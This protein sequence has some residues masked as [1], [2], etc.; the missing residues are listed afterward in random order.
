[1]TATTDYDT[2]ERRNPWPGGS[3][4]RVTGEDDLRL[5]V[6]NGLAG[7]TVVV[8]G[9]VLNCDGELIPFEQKL[10]PTTDRLASTV[11]VRLSEG[12]LVQAHAFVSAGSPLVGQTFALLSV[13]R[14]DAAAAIDLFTLAAGYVTAT[15]RASFPS[16][17][18]GSSLRFDGAIRSITGT[19]PGAGA[20]ISETVPAGARWD[21]LAFF[22]T[23]TTS[24]AA[25]NRVPALFLDDGANVFIKS[26]QQ[27]NQIASLAW[28]YLW[29][30]G[31][32]SQAAGNR[33]IVTSSLPVP[34]RLGAG[35]RLRTNT[36][37]IQAADQWA[38]PQY[39][40]R[41]WI[42]GS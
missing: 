26:S 37:A 14:G 35:Y 2:I 5:T 17:G 15:Q 25:A 28:D 19:A 3:A 23:L 36:T 42:E 27:G 33:L 8:R 1:M 18:V 40:V 20:E 10:T 7:V 4:I 24:V 32:Q 13:I 21:L 22:T 9:R 11:T 31:D 6:L 29:A 39:V 38:A 41:E 12:W 30:P 34:V 16:G